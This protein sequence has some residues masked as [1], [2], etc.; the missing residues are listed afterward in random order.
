MA[1]QLGQYNK[2]SAADDNRFM[3]LVTSGTA[4]RQQAP[5]DS[6]AQGGGSVFTNECVR[7]NL[8]NNTNY[9]FHGKIK[10]LMSSQTIYI[11]L[12]KYTG[13]SAPTDG[14]EQY[15]KTITIAEGDPH[16]WV[17]I[18]FAFTP[19]VSGFT[20]ILFELARTTEDYRI[21]QRY[22]LIIYEELSVI[23]NMITSKIQSGAKL[24]KIGVQSRPGLLMCING[25]EIRASRT[26]IYELRDNVIPVSFFSVMRAAEEAGTSVE[27]IE[28]NL[29]AAWDAAADKSTVNSVCI[30]GAAKTR[31]IDN[32]ILDYIYN[33]E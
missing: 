31:S 11:K 28:T 25:E 32:F 5:G 8:S 17:D 12:I 16:E 6:G 20:A 1:Y 19:I 4:A 29:N 30:F 2:N 7:V 33:E 24:I 26:G 15:I 18:E 21:E 9:Y 3:T 13:E 10:R 23:N 27:T 14:E 22:P